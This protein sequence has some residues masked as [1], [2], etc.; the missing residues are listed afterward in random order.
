MNL[1]RDKDILRRYKAGKAVV[2]LLNKRTAGACKINELL[3]TLFAANW[4]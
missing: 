1:R 2:G 3:W 4:P